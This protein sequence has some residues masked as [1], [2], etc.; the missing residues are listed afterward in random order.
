MPFDKQVQKEAEF[1]RIHLGYHDT[2]AYRNLASEAI[3]HMRF[4]LEQLEPFRGDP[5]EDPVQ[6]SMF[7]EN[8]ADFVKRNED[9]E[10]EDSVQACIFWNVLYYQVIEKARAIRTALLNV[11]ANFTDLTALSGTEE[12]R[13]V[14]DDMVKDL[15]GSAKSDEQKAFMVKAL[16]ARYNLDDLQVDHL[17]KKSLPRLYQLLGRVPEDD[18][19]NND[20]IKKIVK[21]RDQPLGGK[22]DT[23]TKTI[24]LNIGR[25][26]T[27]RGSLNTASYLVNG[28]MEPVR[29]FSATTL[30]E[31]GHAVEKN[32]KFM[33]HNGA[34]ERFGGW[35]NYTLKGIIEV[36][37]TTGGFQEAFGSNYSPDFL[38]LFLQGVIQK[39]KTPEDLCA[40]LWEEHLASYQ[41]LKM[42]RETGIDAFVDD[43]AISKACDLMN[44]W[45]WERTFYDFGANR[46]FMDSCK[47]LREGLRRGAVEEIL[48]LIFNGQEV[49]EAIKFVEEHSADLDNRFAVNFYMEKYREYE[50]FNVA[51]S[52][53]QDIKAHANQTPMGLVKAETMIGH[54]D[55]PKLRAGNLE[56]LDMILDRILHGGI[57][58][59]KAINLAIDEI[60]QRFEGVDEPIEVPQYDVLRRHPTAI[61]FATI[62]H[63][64]SMIYRGG[65]QVARDIAFDGRVYFASYHNGYESYL[66]SNRTTGKVSDYQYRAP[67]EWFAETYAIHYLGKLSNT[68]PMYPILMESDYGQHH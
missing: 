18:V 55:N 50:F 35:Q 67:G 11:T 3:F 36:A 9:I 34:L 59:D 44:V 4:A 5:V 17:S 48:S 26:G 68:H 27:I 40:P 29:V 58:K 64:G 25:S 37:M 47:K 22:Q 56:L 1:M 53:K 39:D 32:H 62:E 23:T 33:K 31:V 63:H 21:N 14:L 2:H 60:A 45:G 16:K 19:R 43:P 28:R 8:L 20:L 46:T 15:K 65:D 13:V 41:T 38:R 54:A 10:R 7:A 66:L 52:L 12:G 24:T 42:I 61:K 57:P 6:Y 49:N 30:H 51:R